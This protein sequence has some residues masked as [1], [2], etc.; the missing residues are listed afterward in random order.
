LNKTRPKLARTEPRAHIGYLVGYES[1]NIYR[2][3]V[4]GFNRVFSTRDVDFDET[5][6]YDPLYDRQISENVRSIVSKGIELDSGET[7]EPEVQ[8]P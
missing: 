8:E 2:I 5:K 4:P 1:I 6:F 7:E 3:W